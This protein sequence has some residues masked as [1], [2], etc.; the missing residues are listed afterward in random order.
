MGIANYV[1]G[2][3]TEKETRWFED[4]EKAMEVE[5]KA[6]VRHG[7]MIEYYD[8]GKKMSQTPYANGMRNGAGFGWH[9]NEKKAFD[10]FYYEGEEIRIIEYDENG[11]RITPELTVS[12]G[13]KRRWKEGEIHSLYKDKA[14]DLVYNVF[15]EP[16]KSG[17]NS[18]RYDQISVGGKTGQV[19]FVFENAK[20]KDVRVMER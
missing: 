3:K 4:G 7:N 8:N 2:K 6:G 10:V 1:F 18:W 16:D 13:R 5:W 14:R 9:E 17:D 20:V 15:G 19:L 12:L 11:T